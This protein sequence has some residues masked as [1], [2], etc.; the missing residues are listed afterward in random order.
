MSNIYYFIVR[1]FK[2]KYLSIFKYN[3]HMEI[4]KVFIINLKERTDRRE[5]IEKELM[6][7]DMKIMNFLMQ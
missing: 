7:V 6:R 3:L 5:A 4:D 2:Y 1:I